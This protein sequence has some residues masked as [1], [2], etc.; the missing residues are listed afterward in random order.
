MFGIGPIV[1]TKKSIEI[2][3]NIFLF[4][5]FKNLDCNI[6][7]LKSEIKND[8]ELTLIDSGNGL[9]SKNLMQGM[10]KIGLDPSKIKRILLTHEHLDHIL[11][12]YN[13]PELASSKPEIYALGET[14]KI[15]EQADEDAIAP[16]E[17][18]IPVSLFQVDIKPL[19]VKRLK[20]GD[21]LTFG[22]FSFK[23]L[24]T[25]GHSLGS[26][27]LFEKKLKI[28]FPGD[29]VFC[30]GSFGRVDFPGGSAKDLRQSISRLTELDVSILCPGHLAYSKNGSKEIKLSL[31]TF[32]QFFDEKN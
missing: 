30:G 27:S 16:K 7:I 28:L 19:D 11:G 25:P 20:E 31:H 9:N 4:A 22:D 32:D 2:I 10:K 21:E 29:V 15:I 5:E 12:I 13:I 23:I 17:L 24:Y 18:G 14:A 1:G 6:Y 26:I 8:Y 3:K